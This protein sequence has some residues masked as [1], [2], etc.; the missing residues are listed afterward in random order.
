[1]R[2]VLIATLGS[3]GDLNPALVLGHALTSAGYQ[4]RIAA[5]SMHD[6]ATRRQGFEFVPIGR[7]PDPTDLTDYACEEGMRD[8]GIAFV[9]HANFSQLDALCE[10]L[11]SA[12]ERADVML[13]AYHVVPAHLVAAKQEIPLLSY[14][15]SP[16]YFVEQSHMQ[17]ARAG[18]PIPARWHVLL[19]AQRR[20]YGLPS[21]PFPYTA[22]FSDPATMLGLFPRF[23][24]DKDYV[25]PLREMGY[26]PIKVVGFWQNTLLKPVAEPDPA[27]I[28]F[29]DERTVV[30]S[31][32]SF[33]DR[34][35][36]PQRMFD[37]SV[38][39]CRAL[40][41]KC[42]YLSRYVER[43]GDTDDV[44]VR[45]FVDHAAIF[46]R[47]GAIFHHAGLGTL[48]AACAAGKPMV[49]VPFIHDGPYHAQ[50]MAALIG[51]PIVPA[52][53]Y[54][55]ASLVVALRSA[56][57]RAPEMRRTLAELMAGEADGCAAVVQEVASLT[58]AAARPET[59]A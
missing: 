24:L 55:L 58:N 34:D 47:A 23:L 5:N 32:G 16:A 42:L 18:A 53:E 56:L 27:L 21:R 33:A 25:S 19:A 51:A 46:P 57:E 41:L 50:R 59:V 2:R 52:D 1:M 44:M 6:A 7:Y 9:D 4:V 45:P 15:L 28:G 29:C 31:F 49:T 43:H 3:L 54:D 17:G 30:F 39:A 13:A 8:E 35:N 40:S 38:A 26:P 22:V 10:D 36:H 11:S 48:T 12:A 20:R 14:T 37:I